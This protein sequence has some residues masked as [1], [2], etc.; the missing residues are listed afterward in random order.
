MNF[1]GQNKEYIKSC[2]TIVVMLSV[3]LL[4][5]STEPVLKLLNIRMGGKKTTRRIDGVSEQPFSYRL[6]SASDDAGQWQ[7]VEDEDEK[8]DETTKRST[9]R[10]RDSNESTDRELVEDLVPNIQLALNC[11]CLLRLDKKYL[12]PFLVRRDRLSSPMSRQRRIVVGSSSN[13]SIDLPDPVSST[14]MNSRDM[15]LPVLGEHESPFSFSDTKNNSD[16]DDDGDGDDHDGM[17][18][19]L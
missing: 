6:K 19:A 12:K 3:L 2:T 4:G 1:P 15:I 14:A 17:E 13:R 18:V 11:T 7:I 9:P 10:R 5:G 8:N 16:N